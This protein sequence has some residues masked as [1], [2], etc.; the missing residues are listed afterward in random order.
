[1]F[2]HEVAP[3]AVRAALAKCSSLDAAPCGGK[4]KTSETLM[5]NPKL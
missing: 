3:K 1:M 2:V 5:N 4:L